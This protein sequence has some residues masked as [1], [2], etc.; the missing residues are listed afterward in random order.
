MPFLVTSVIDGDTFDVKPCWRVKYKTGNR[1]TGNRVRIANVDAP[2]L[3][4]CGGRTAKKALEELIDGKT[5][6]L[7][8]KAV[9][10]YDRLVAEVSHNGVDIALFLKIE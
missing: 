2:E 7:K 6:H 5:V 4:T 8:P 9:D 10:K 3:G 1:R